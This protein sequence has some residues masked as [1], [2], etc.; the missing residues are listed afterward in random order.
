M[1]LV[2][3]GTGLVGSHLMYELIAQGE[4]KLRATYRTIESIEP[5]RDLFK[6]K[7]KENT[8][9][10]ALL[11]KHIEWVEADVTDIPALTEAFDDIT[12]VY[13]CAALISFNPRDFERLQKINVE[14]T[15]NVINLCIKNKVTKVCYVSSVAALGNSKGA[16]TE[17]THWEA[18]KENSVYSISKFASEMQV[19]RG[20][21]EGLDVVIVNP[22]IILGE[23][24]YK[25]G[26]GV[27]FKK[28]KKGLDY[29]VPGSS[30][31]VDVL[32]V[33]N[34]M[35]LLMRS[36][37][38]NERYILVG[39]N[40]GFKQ[41]FEQ[42]AIALQVALPTKK[43]KNWQLELAWRLDWVASLFGK[44]RRLFRTTARSAYTQVIYDTTKIKNQLAFKYTP[45]EETINR[46]ANHFN[47]Q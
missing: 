3:G 40:L 6:W 38:V 13:H 16:I 37:Q 22:G 43:V 8:K 42:I 27:F 24:F 26:S 47:R 31:F 20:T 14:G 10:A 12:F 2:T 18:N 28:I 39:H 41:V 36:K 17:E 7:A 44:K 45:L 1:I 21:Q 15:A 35:I 9:Q 11:F 34:A 29:M 30:G 46:I 23:G 33:V 5:V 25:Q 4:T 32:D 19:W